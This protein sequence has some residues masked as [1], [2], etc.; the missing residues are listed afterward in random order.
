MVG[1]PT[2]YL[3]LR[4]VSQVKQL[5]LSDLSVYNAVFVFTIYLHMLL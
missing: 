2:S 4:F 1:I 5:K 3:I